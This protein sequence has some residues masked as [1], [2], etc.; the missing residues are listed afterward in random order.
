MSGPQVVRWIW[1]GVFALPWVFSMEDALFDRGRQPLPLLTV[2]VLTLA[3]IILAAAGFRSDPSDRPRPRSLALLELAPL[4]AVGSVFFG[5]VILSAAGYFGEEWFG[6]THRSIDAIGGGLFGLAGF[7]AW[8]RFWR[9]L[10]PDE[11]EENT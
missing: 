7:C 5:S 4:W 6:E 3:A 11:L 10:F 8:K 9:R 1:F 2:S